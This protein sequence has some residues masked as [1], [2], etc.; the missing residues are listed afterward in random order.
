MFPSF[1][2]DERT[3][4]NILFF[5]RIEHWEN[6]LSFLGECYANPCRSTT[7]SCRDGTRCIPIRNNDT[8]NYRCVCDDYLSS[9]SNNGLTKFQS[10]CSLSLIDRCS[11]KP[12]QINEQCINEYPN[13]FSCICL[14][15][16]SGS[17]NCCEIC[18]HNSKIF[19]QYD[20]RSFSFEFHRW[21][22]FIELY[23]EASVRYWWKI[24]SIFSWSLVFVWTSVW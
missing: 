2:R 24:V 21:I 7:I 16:S 15:C 5:L 8:D 23:K 12:C 3:S 13:S 18:A 4:R 10:D 19:D 17:F 11:S 6:R 20:F 1:L 9:L 14:N 22:S